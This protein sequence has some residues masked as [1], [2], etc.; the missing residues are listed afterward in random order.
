MS[1][2]SAAP[3]HSSVPY[4]APA[5]IAGIGTT[6]WGPDVG[7]QT[8]WETVTVRYPLVWGELRS[9]DSRRPRSSGTC[10]A[11][12][13]RAWNVTAASGSA[14]SGAAFARTPTTLTTTTRVMISTGIT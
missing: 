12:T 1:T 5:E 2:A 8:R 10:S 7:F 11:R 6:H 13:T 4:R 14:G 9:V 3:A